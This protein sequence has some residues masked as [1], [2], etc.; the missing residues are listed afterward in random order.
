VQIQQAGINEYATSLPIAAGDYIG[1]DFEDS[2]EDHGLDWVFG[3]GVYEQLVYLAFDGSDSTPDFFDPSH[4]LFNADVECKGTGQSQGP[5]TVPSNSFTIGKVVGRRV[6]VNIASAGQIQI[7]DGTRQPKSKGKAKD[8]KA[9]PKLLKPSS[10]RGG[11]GNVRAPLKLTKAAQAILKGKGKV[12]VQAR[13]A[14]T[15][16]GGTAATQTKKLT[17][18]KAAPKGKAA[19]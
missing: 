5:P 16:D 15:P 4:Y 13:V 12:K 7:V 6:L 10:V 11:P 14:F 17:I 8:K 19:K 1:I 18:R 2:T 9:K 3:E